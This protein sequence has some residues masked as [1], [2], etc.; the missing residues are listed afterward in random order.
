V[1]RLRRCHE[2]N[3]VQ[4]TSGRSVG[5]DVGSIEAR[6]RCAPASTAANPSRSVSSAACF[7]ERERRQVGERW[8]RFF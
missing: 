2:S 3:F 5:A 7:R 1:V 4:Q 6:V 8:D